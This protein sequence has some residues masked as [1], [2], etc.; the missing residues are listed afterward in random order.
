VEFNPLTYDG[1]FELMV[2]GHI[3]VWILPLLLQRLRESAPHARLRTLSACEAPL[4]MLAA[5]ELDFVL[6]AEHKTYQEGFRLTTLGY[7][8]PVL[9]ARR[10]HPLEG[11]P[12]TWEALQQYPHV[13]LII[14]EL[15]D[16]QFQGQIQS[17]EESEFFQRES[18]VVPQLYTDH[19]YTAIR[20]VLTSDALFPAPPLFMEQDEL[21]K[22]L[23]ALPL[24]DDEEISIKYVMVTHERVD[25]SP[26]HQFLRG[27][28]LY[29]IENFRDKYGLPC[30]EDLRALKQ[31][32]Y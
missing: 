20:T 24:P 15:E 30:L 2:Q 13:R 26:A 7:A 28:I 21:A 6:H 11:A 19:L 10:G 27:E 22:D 32:T 12:L 17:L 8:P 25:S 1:E 3:G 16:I 14:P 23:V 31:L 9:L 5:G 29:I 4:A 18:E